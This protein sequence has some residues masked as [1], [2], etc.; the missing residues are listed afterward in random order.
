M[1]SKA[2]LRRWRGN[3][4]ITELTERVKPVFGWRLFQAEDDQVPGVWGRSKHIA[5]ITSLSMAWFFVVIVHFVH[6]LFLYTQMFKFQCR[7]N[8]QVFTYGLFLYFKEF[9]LMI[10]QSHC[11]AYIKLVCV[12]VQLLQSCLTLCDPMGCS[13]P[14]SSVHGIL[15]ARILE[16]VAM[17]FSMGS[18]W[19]WDW[20]CICWRHL[21]YRQIPFPLS[22]LGSPK[23]V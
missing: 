4:G 22:H 19:P 2:S 3:R 7:K 12:C 18:S 9:F 20:T 23:M 14:G 6:D 21:H 15:Q 1:D 5:N 13:P 8:F 16:W 17:P 10:Q 11:W